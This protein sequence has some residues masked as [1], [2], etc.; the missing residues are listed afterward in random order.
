[1]FFF[2]LWIIYTVWFTTPVS[3]SNLVREIEEEIDF[4]NKQLVEQ[5]KELNENISGVK[6]DKPVKFK[7]VDGVKLRK[8]AKQGKDQRDTVNIAALATVS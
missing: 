2:L 6:K 5:L 7:S 3:L 1:M 4:T 8:L